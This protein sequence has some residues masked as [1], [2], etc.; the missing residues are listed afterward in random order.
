VSYPADNPGPG[1]WCIDKRHADPATLVT[2]ARHGQGR[3]WLARWVDHDG[4]ERSRSFDRKAEAQH[5]VAEVTGKMAGGTYADPRRAGATFGTL[6]DQWVA[7]K[8]TL[9]PKT[10]A[11]YEALLET[12]ILPKW[13]DVKLRDID[14]AG[15][16]RWI[17]WL[18]TDPDARQR[19][20]DRGGLSGARVIQAHQVLHQVLGFAVRAKYIAANPADAIQLPRKATPEKIA[21]THDQVRQ[22]A[23]ASSEIS[24][25]V[26]TLAYSGIRYGEAAALRV[27]DVDITRRR[28]KVSR[29][30]TRVR[31][32]GLV[33]GRTKTH[34]VRKVPVPSFVADKLADAIEGRG[35]AEYLFPGPDGPMT[36]GWF[37]VRFDRACAKVGLEGVTPHT[38]RHTAGS[39]ALASGVS[40]VTVQKLL[41]HR[42]ATTT[43][44][45]YSHMLPDD[46]DNLA[47]AL[48]KAARVAAK[49]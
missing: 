22:L 10:Y 36:V 32:M 4:N 3:R 49:T 48:D 9:K 35:Q 2:T 47:A 16:Q 23:E 34:A 40:V 21:L 33:E 18:S 28:L 11:G 15:V 6:A 17:T 26:Y 38:L 24:T 46:F 41:G 42:N 25:M 29:S 45:M 12:L 1:S 27:S 14:H 44:N 20:K 43:L 39:L 30:I 7:S 19:G 37:R 31:K 8:A 5:H 13:R